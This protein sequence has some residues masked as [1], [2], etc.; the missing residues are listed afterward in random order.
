MGSTAIARG[1]QPADQE[2]ALARAEKRGVNHTVAS[3]S[4][5]VVLLITAGIVMSIYL[6]P[7]GGFGGGLWAMV[8]LCAVIMTLVVAAIV[9]PYV[10]EV[11]SSRK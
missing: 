4:I 8:V 5:C 2:T 10:K 3:A 9:I 7:E 6:A 1:G 11:S